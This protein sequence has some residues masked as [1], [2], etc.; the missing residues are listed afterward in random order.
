MLAPPQGAA[1][2]LGSLR[3]QAAQ[4]LSTGCPG[5]HQRPPTGAP[6][7]PTA[8]LATVSTQGVFTPYLAGLKVPVVDDPG[9]D[10]SLV[11]PVAVAAVVETG[12]VTLPG[13]ARDSP[14]KGTEGESCITT[15]VSP[16][17]ANDPASN[18][19]GLSTLAGSRIAGR[20]IPCSAS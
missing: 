2:E 11:I 7:A 19:A 14:C 17:Q 9:R 18:A 16:A 8:P 1:E 6:A 13:L 3:G 5:S 15:L 10:D 20:G 12:V 4:G